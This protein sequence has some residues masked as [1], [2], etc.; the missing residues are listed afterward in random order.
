[1]AIKILPVLIVI[2]PNSNPIANILKNS[3]QFW[4]KF[5][6]LSIVKEWTNPNRIEVINSAGLPR[7]IDPIKILDFNEL[8]R[9]PSIMPLNANSSSIP[10]IVNWYS[11]CSNLSSEY[12]IRKDNAIVKVK[13]NITAK[14]IG[15]NEL[16]FCL[17][18]I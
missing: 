5:Q 9:M 13:I 7:L 4:L 17:K 3:N 8:E 16:L 14:R 10:G 2:Q 1:M 6:L 18:V 12:F 11:N 15:L